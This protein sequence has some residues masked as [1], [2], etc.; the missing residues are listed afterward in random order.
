MIQKGYQSVTNKFQLIGLIVC[1][2]AL[3]V[4]ALPQ[5]D[6]PRKMRPGRYIPELHGGS[7]G[8]WVPDNSGKYFHIHR[9]YDGGYGDR[10]IKYV[11]DARGNIIRRPLSS[12]P[13]QF[14]KGPLG[15]DDHI[16]FMIDFNYN[17]TGWQ[18]LKFEWNRDGDEEHQYNIEVSNHLWLTEDEQALE[19]QR[20]AEYEKNKNANNGDEGTVHVDGVYN[21]EE[22]YHY[23]YT[24][25]ENAQSS[26]AAK[27]NIQ[28]LQNSLKEVLDYIQKSVIPGL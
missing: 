10:G 22:G 5:E 13:T 11:H 1:L 14:L 7:L 27:Q 24:N 17:G 6:R 16:R 21:D 15:P 26:L 9:P 19:D 23:S 12:I 28:N 2:S 18:I 20:V 4:N 8:K 3:V 25:E